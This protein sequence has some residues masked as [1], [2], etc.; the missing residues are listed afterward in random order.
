LAS[1]IQDNLG[2]YRALGKDLP[3]EISKAMEIYQIDEE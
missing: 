3:D 2:E 1:H